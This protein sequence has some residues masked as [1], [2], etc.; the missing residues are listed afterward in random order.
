MSETWLHEYI[1]L[2]FRIHRLMQKA[3]ECPFV[4]AYYGPP[5][6]RTQAESEPE[7]EASELVHLAM[8]LADALPAQGFVSNRVAYLDKHV[9][10]MEM[11]SRKLSGEYF[12][13]EQEAKF[14]LD[15]HHKW[16]H[17]EQFEQAHALYET[18]LPGV[19]SLAE[20][21]RAYQAELAYPEEHMNNLAKYIDLAFAEAKRRTCSFIELPDDEVIDI[22]YLAKWE[23][24]A[25]AYYSG[26]FRTHIVMNVASTVTYISRRFDHKVCHEGYPGHHTEYTLKEQQLYLQRGYIEQTICLTL[27]TQCVIQEGIAMLAHEMIF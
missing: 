17:E 1:L 18:V 14:C 11:L 9:T 24:D 4:E 27:W 19:G 3:Y 23:H 10:A 13:L 5:N 26:N 20:R 2:A 15:I 16:T 7:F 6:W 21:L 12:S 8:M 25:A 22:Q